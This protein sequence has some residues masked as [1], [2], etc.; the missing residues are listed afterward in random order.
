MGIRKILP[1]NMNI[2]AW[3]SVKIVNCLLP[4]R[5]LEMNT[6]KPCVPN[7]RPLCPGQLDYI[8]SQL[9]MIKTIN[10]DSFNRLIIYPRRRGG[11]EA[12]IW[13]LASNILM[14]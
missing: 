11:G 6:C 2:S 10:T 14:S 5:H 3:E 9:F 7:F 8:I 1:Y 4:I 12:E 13:I